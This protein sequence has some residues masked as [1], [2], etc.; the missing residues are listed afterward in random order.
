VE[1]GGKTILDEMAGTAII[2][3]FVENKNQCI[4]R[5]ANWSYWM[6][7]LSFSGAFEK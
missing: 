4:A 6:P 1:G 5:N 3:D 7:T 2:A